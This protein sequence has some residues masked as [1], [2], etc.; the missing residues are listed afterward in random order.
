MPEEYALNCPPIVALVSQGTPGWNITVRLANLEQSL[1][2]I[3][4]LEAA[5]NTAIAYARDLCRQNKVNEPK[6]LAFPEWTAVEGT[7]A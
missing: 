2:G 1:N 4:D 6:G 3:G 5:K 7:S